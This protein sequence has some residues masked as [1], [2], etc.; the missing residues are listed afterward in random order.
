MF[1]IY[2]LFRAFGKDRFRDWKKAVMKTN[3]GNLSG[4][5]KEELFVYEG[6]TYGVKRWISYSLISHAVRYLKLKDELRVMDEIANFI[7]M[8][9]LPEPDSHTWVLYQ[10]E[11]RFG[12]M[13]VITCKQDGWVNVSAIA[14]DNGVD[15]DCYTRT[16]RKWLR[17]ELNLIWRYEDTDKSSDEKKPSYADLYKRYSR[18]AEQYL[19]THPVLALT[20]AK[21]INNVLHYFMLSVMTGKIPGKNLLD[22]KYKNYGGEPDEKKIAGVVY[23][24]KEIGEKNNKTKIGYTCNPEYINRL[25]DLQTGNPNELMVYRVIPCFNPRKLE[26]HLHNCYQVQHIRGE[27]YNLTLGQIESIAD[28]ITGKSTVM[29]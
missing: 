27:W 28:H 24:I 25:N 16:S 1:D 29:D 6:K 4:E 14:K 2:P 11:K 23:F 15:I 26:Q 18:M 5:S 17:E 3:I 19:W 21:R 22:H 12:N 13:C 8:S 20:I 7:G 9:T 10:D